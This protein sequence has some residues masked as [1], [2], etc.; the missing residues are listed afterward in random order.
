MP[1]GGSLIAANWLA[2]SAAK[3]GTVIATLPS[4]V[5][6][7]EML[8]NPA[9]RFDARAM[10][11][12]CSL[13]SF[14]PVA[15]VWYQT[16]FVT[17]RDLITHEV[18]VGASGASSNN[19]VTPNLLNSL[20]HTKFKVINGYE[21]GGGVE[22]A[23]ERGEVQAMVGGD[24]DFVKATK[25]DWLRDKKIR[26]LLQAT[27]TR[28]PELP[29]VPTVLELVPPENH[30]VLALL[31]ARQSYSGLFLAPAG[32]SAPIVAT[33]RAGFIKM[34][35]DAEFKRDAEQSRLT[36]HPANADEV[37]ATLGGLLAS[38]QSITDR[39]TAELRRIIPQ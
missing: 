16:P 27:L 7:E 35:E 15:A 36:I 4:G 11:L 13:D 14:S 17:A 32:V 34:I 5:L 2:N 6:F 19:S 23:L 30:D 18:L 3:D 9:A 26:V 22:L 10:N 21:G 33:L 37:T 24:W 29:D 39:A 20:L 25:S 12:L 38:P 28:N 8:G 31:I 1:G